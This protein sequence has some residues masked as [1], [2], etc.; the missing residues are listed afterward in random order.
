MGLKSDIKKAFLENIKPND[1][2][3]PTK[4]G[5]AKYDKLGQ[6]I[7]DAIVKFTVAQTLRV[8]K[9][10]ASQANVPAITPVGPGTVPLLTVKVDDTGGAVDNVIGGGKPESMT[11]AVVLKKEE[12][13]GLG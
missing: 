5:E 9:L 6:D 4:E 11:S 7:E 12:V 8:T 1:D 3:Q 13:K 2:W 10:N